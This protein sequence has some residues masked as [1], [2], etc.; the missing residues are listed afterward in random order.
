MGPSEALIKPTL[1]IPTEAEFLIKPT[2]VIPT[3]AELPS[4]RQFCVVEGPCVS[5][6]DT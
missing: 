1:V 4:F 6:R 2:L 3:E 5:L